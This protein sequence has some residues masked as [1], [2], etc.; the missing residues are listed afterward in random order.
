MQ[1]G[2]PP[3]PSDPALPDPAAS[4]IE[5]VV[6]V[7]MENRSFDHFVG[8]LPGADGR[9][10]GLVYRDRAGTPHPTRPLA[11]DF[12]GC[13]H[14]GPDHSYAGG[15]VAYADGA[16]DGWLRA[17]AND[18]YAIGYYTGADLAFLGP[19]ARAWTVCDR[20]FAAIM[21]ETYPNR[22]YQ[23]AAQTDR[24]GDS[25]VPTGLPTIWDRLAARGLAGRY[26]FSDVPFLALWGLRYLAI[27]RP[28]GDFLADCA[29]GALPPV[30]FVDP[31]F[32]GGPLGTSGDDHPPADV[33][34]G[35]AFLARVYAAV[36][37]GPGWPATV[38]VLTFDEWGGFFDHVPPPRAPL[39]PA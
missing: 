19:A 10:A 27:A 26:Y 14:P 33:R 5:H 13:G 32:L 15:R 12:Q 8:W 6:V 22:L 9:Q 7:T 35:E 17:G 38:L 28:F 30:A 36:V 1:G 37:A 25:L 31:R 2:A 39:P 18:P 23:H 20:Y 16:C 21:A 29:A 4:G 24:L 3:E 34:N 11:P